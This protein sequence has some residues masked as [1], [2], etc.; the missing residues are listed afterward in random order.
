MIRS[1]YRVY[2]ICK[3]DN[4]KALFHCWSNKDTFLLKIKSSLRPAEQWAVKK[5]FEEM[6]ECSNT[7]QLIPDN[8]EVIG[9]TNKFGGI[10][11]FE[12]GTI[13][14]VQPTDITFLDSEGIF[15]EYDFGGLNNG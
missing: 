5:A 6:L 1:E 12:D 2:R 7:M 10:V 8:L 4:K 14:M 3:V 13:K 11:E 9:N 15:S